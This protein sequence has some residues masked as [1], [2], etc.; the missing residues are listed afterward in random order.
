MA[1]SCRTT[2]SADAAAPSAA[3]ASSGVFFFCG[4]PFSSAIA[5]RSCLRARLTLWLA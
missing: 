3:A 1:A 5:R 4:E 2:A